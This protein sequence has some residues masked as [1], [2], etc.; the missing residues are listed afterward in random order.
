MDVMGV[1]INSDVS[2]ITKEKKFVLKHLTVGGAHLIQ[3]SKLPLKGFRFLGGEGGAQG[4][5]GY[6]SIFL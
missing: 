6:Y 5:C 3:Q 1:E 2:K 4:I